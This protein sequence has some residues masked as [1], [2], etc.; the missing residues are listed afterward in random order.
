MK[1]GWDVSA[2]ST[3]TWA[4]F[5]ASPWAYGGHAHTMSLTFGIGQG[6]TINFL[7]RLEVII[8]I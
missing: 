8:P 2:T 1:S 3:D 5:K 6:R 7:L 4:L